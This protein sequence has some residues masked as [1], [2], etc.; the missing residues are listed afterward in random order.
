MKRLV[1]RSTEY[2][3]LLK[4]Y[5]HWLRSLGYADQTIKSFPVH[6]REFMYWLEQRHCLSIRNLKMEYEEEYRNYLESRENEVTGGGLSSYAI[7]KQLVSINNFMSYLL[8]HNRGLFTLHFKTIECTGKREILNKKE[9]KSLYEVS[10]EQGREGKYFRGQRDRAILGIYYG[11]GL[12]LSEGINL[13]VDDID[14]RNQKLLVRK[15]KGRKE[16]EVPIALGCL[17]DLEEYIREGRE[18]YLKKDTDALLLN[19]YGSRLKSS[20]IY[21]NLSRLKSEAMIIK[22]TSVHGLRHSVATHLLRAGMNLDKIRE[23]LGH[24]SLE[25]TQIYTHIAYEN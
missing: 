5:E 19:C 8:A 15:G 9:V 25:S 12:R 16:R 1:I 10:R 6:V 23:F 3:E 14:F 11:C 13:D 18:W 4:N 21:Y 24:A 17:D 20:G 2:Q 22:D 7:N